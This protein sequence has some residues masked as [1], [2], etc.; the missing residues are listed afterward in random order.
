MSGS[1][2]Y[3]IIGGGLYGCATAYNL[4]R[5]GA[6]NIVVLERKQVCAGGTAKSCA[7]IRTHYSVATNLM[8]AVASLRIF[9]DFDQRVGGQVGFHR[10]GYLIVGPEEHRG[11]M[12]EVFHTQNEHGIDTAVLTPA[13]AQKIHPLLS[14]HDVDVIGYDTQTG[15][16]DPYLTTM[17][18]A[19][20]ARDLGVTIVT[21]APVTGLQ[22]GGGVKTVST[23]GGD[24]QAPVVLLAAGPWTNAIAQP[25]G[26]RFDYVISR[27]KVI[28]LRIGR[29]YEMTW[30]IIKDLTTPDKIYFRPETGGVV[31]VGTGDH[32]DP[33][34]D[35]DILTDNVGMDHVA[36]IDRLIS[37]RMPAFAEAEF[38]AGWTG[39]YDITPDWNPLVG[40][41]P[42]AEGAF[43][44][45]GFSGHG[46]KLAPTISDSLAQTML[47][48]APDLPIADYAVDRFAR[49]RTLH[50]A[51]GIG[52][53]S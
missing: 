31:L 41:V 14:F 48:Q 37:N 34:D 16:A 49:G 15:F 36:R 40:A 10:T 46:F 17:A 12:L 18:Y 29:P 38:T 42:G 19:Q 33:I 32:G 5:R 8:H 3:L 52:S 50:G 23:P 27:H 24:F 21:D 2:D 30:P 7:I 6:K 1:A 53:I 28:T 35:A 45:V 44:A 43:V 26:L 11:P 9:A 22:L 25:A 47:G 39:P 20:R 13:E 4:A 51:Y